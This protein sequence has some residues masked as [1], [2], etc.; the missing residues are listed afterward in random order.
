MSSRPSGSLISLHI[1]ILGCVSCKPSTLIASCL[2]PYGSYSAYFTQHAEQASQVGESDPISH[3][4][5]PEASH[6]AQSE[7]P[8]PH[9]GI[10]GPT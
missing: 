1:L 5:L 3:P 8:A 2:H 7:T 9:H 10:Q 4:D 6:W